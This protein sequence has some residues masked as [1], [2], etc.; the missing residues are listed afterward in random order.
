MS[1]KLVRVAVVAATKECTR[2]SLE[3]LRGRFPTAANCSGPAAEQ[4]DCEIAL[5]GSSQMRLNSPMN[6]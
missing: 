1:Q 5:C 6:Q 4:W 2:H 3:R